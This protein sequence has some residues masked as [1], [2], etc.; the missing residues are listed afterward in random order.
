VSVIGE[1]I[2]VEEAD[3]TEIRGLKVPL[4][5]L[6]RIEDR[7]LDL[8][9]PPTTGT[10][11]GPLSGKTSSGRKRILRAVEAGQLSS[12]GILSSARGSQG[13]LRM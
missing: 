11:I 3:S 4:V 5:L 7:I 12:S 2:G 8:P 13:M 10:W 9:D 1:S 6:L